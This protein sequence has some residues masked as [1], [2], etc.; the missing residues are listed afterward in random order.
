VSVTGHDP[1]RQLSD[2][3]WYSLRA[4]LQA[5]ERLRTRILP[6]TTLPILHQILHSR[7]R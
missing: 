1:E 7:E 3:H 6:N 2:C 4:R 5:P